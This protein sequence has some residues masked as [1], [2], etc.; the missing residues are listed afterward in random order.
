VDSRT[1]PHATGPP[2]SVSVAVLDRQRLTRA[3]VNTAALR[4]LVELH[5]RGW[6]SRAELEAEFGAPYDRL[7]AVA[8]IPYWRLS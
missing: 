2:Q 5:H 8:A 7:A 1:G 4:R 6:L 3:G